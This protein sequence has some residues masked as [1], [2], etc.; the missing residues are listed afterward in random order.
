M[1]N[2]KTVT[3]P[4]EL[5]EDFA[6]YAESGKVAEPKMVEQLRALLEKSDDADKVNNRQM[7]LMQFV[8]KNAAPVVERQEP[9]PVYQ[10]SWT[11]DGGG[12]WID[13][14]K[15]NYE[16]FSKRQN[17]ITRTLYTSPPAPVAVSLWYIRVPD[18]P[19]NPESPC[20]YFYAGSEWH[21]DQLLGKKGAS[22]ANEYACLDKVKELNQPQCKMCD[23]N[24]GRLPCTCKE[25]NQ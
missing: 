24:Q 8:D 6:S 18:E 10:S 4:L 2:D 19:E 3:M 25:L 1:T 5:A 14:D 17:H 23:G 15:E 7:G 12:R 22:I 21:R 9:V 20:E 13:V 16:H 11:G